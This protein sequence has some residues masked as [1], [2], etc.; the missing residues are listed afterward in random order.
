MIRGEVTGNK[1]AL[2]RFGIMDSYG[3]LSPLEA[4]LDTGFTGDLSL[5]LNAIHR[6]GLPALG[7]RA[8]TLADGT[9]SAM[10]AFSATVFWHEIPRR[11]VVIQSEDEP[12]AG[13]GLLWGSRISFEAL[14][15]GNVTIEQI[16]SKP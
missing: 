13:M 7:Q 1:T 2:I 11:V 9:R 15:G 3:R 14:D 10:N 8:F 16:I 6:L 12:L 5:P 4:I